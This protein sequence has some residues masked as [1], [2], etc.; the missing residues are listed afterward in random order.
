MIYMTCK[1]VDQQ[2]E[3]HTLITTH[4]VIVVGQQLIRI[5]GNHL[6][7]LEKALAQAV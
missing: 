7:S 5:G 2:V 1:V 3:A 6:E 4:G